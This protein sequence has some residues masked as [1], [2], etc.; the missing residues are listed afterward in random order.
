MRKARLVFIKQTF[1]GPF[2]MRIAVLPL[3]RY[4]EKQNI[5]AGVRDI[6]LGFLAEDSKG[7][8]AQMEMFSRQVIPHFR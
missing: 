8:F 7:L 6:N 3:G 5:D 1:N 2:A 4:I